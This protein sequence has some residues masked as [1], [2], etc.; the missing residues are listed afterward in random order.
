M[1]LIQTSSEIEESVVLV[2]HTLKPG[3]KI[4]L[5]FSFIQLVVLYFGSDISYSY[6]LLNEKSGIDVVDIKIS[7]DTNL[8]LR[9]TIVILSI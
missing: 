6:M 8:N 5:D 7:N 3:T 2:L 1:F 9:V 4:F